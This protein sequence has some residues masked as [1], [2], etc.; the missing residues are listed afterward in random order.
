MKSKKGKAA[1]AV[2][3]GRESRGNVLAGPRRAWGESDLVDFPSP[4]ALRL[5]SR[6]FSLLRQRL[7]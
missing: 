7:K 1:R 3:R 4:R 5:E 2:A 6:P